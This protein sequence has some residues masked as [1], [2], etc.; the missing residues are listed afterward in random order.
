M[1]ALQMQMGYQTWK[2]IVYYVSIHKKKLLIVY[3]VIW[4][5]SVE[6]EFEIG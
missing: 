6:I 4:R 1:R 2:E 5:K 3:F